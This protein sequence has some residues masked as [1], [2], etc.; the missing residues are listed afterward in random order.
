MLPSRAPWLALLAGLLL[1]SHAAAQ[2]VKLDQGTRGVDRP[3]KNDSEL[4]LDQINRANCDSD[5]VINF[6]LEVTNGGTHQVGAWTGSG[7]ENE[8]DRVGSD[9]SCRRV[10][11]GVPW[12]ENTTVL[13]I[14]VREIIAAVNETTSA[15]EGSGGAGGDDP[16]CSGSAQ[17]VEFTLHFL[18]TDSGGRY[19]GTQT[20]AQWPAAFDLKGPSAPTGVNA[21]IGE[22][23][24]IVSWTAPSG[25]QASEIEGYYFFCDPPPGTGTPTVDGGTPSCGTPTLDPANAC[26]SALSSTATNGET[27]ALTNGVSYAVG[28]AARDTFRNYGTLSSTK[29]ATPQPVTGF[30]EAYRDAG[31]KG[32]GGFC[33]IGGGRSSALAGL[34]A[35]ALLALAL[36]R[37]TARTRKGRAS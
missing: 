7:C 25:T 4:E 3:Q 23:R 9:A 37:R 30:F 26:G 14:P 13:S 18:L 35:V 11:T 10:G 32:G 15:E 16:L 36:R 19:S 22:N 17:P 2:S 20:S 24:L 31:G 5:E 33:S 6:R 34:G 21:G 27:S 1:S 12:S 29:C 8:G 28:V